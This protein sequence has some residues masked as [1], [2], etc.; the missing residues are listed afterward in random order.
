VSNEEGGI[1]HGSDLF[2]TAQRGSDP[3]MHRGSEHKVRDLACV[4]F[5]LQ[6]CG[7]N[8]PDSQLH[9]ELAMDESVPL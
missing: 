1:L 6:K 8:L 4:K 7:I 9:P 3:L 2:W 5:F